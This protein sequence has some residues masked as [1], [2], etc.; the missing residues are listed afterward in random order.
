MLDLCMNVKPIERPI[1]DKIELPEFI[2]NVSENQELPEGKLLYKMWLQVELLTNA[3]NKL[4][5]K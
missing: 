2:N 4:I 5:S 3:V 1:E